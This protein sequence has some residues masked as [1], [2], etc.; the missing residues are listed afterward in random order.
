MQRWFDAARFA[1]AYLPTS[2]GQRDLKLAAVYAH[3]SDSEERERMLRDMATWAEQVQD[4]L[5]IGGDF[6]CTP[7]QSDAVRY[8][9]SQGW[10]DIQQGGPGTCLA[11]GSNEYRRIDFILCNEAAREIVG[12][13]W[14]DVDSAFPTHRPVGVNLSAASG[15]QCDEA[16]TRK[17][18]QPLEVQNGSEAFT[19]EQVDVTHGTEL[20]YDT[21]ARQAE[22]L[23][24]KAAVLAGKDVSIKQQGR[25][26]LHKLKPLQPLIY[27]RV[28]EHESVQ[29]RRCRRVLSALEE[30]LHKIGRNEEYLPSDKDRATWLKIGRRCKANKVDKCLALIGNAE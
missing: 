26:Q 22:G 18:P 1:Y 24:V 20:A 9:L 30:L 15:L 17:T 10:A 16:M 6:N 5:I 8:L 14:T 19:W 2:K 25:Y 23:L 3:A 29:V 11:S 12:S 4:P 28:A 13:S 21:W 7:E 27:D